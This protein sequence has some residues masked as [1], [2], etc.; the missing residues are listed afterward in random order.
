MLSVTQRTREIGIRRAVG[1]RS[2]EVLLQFILESITLSMGG[3]MIG[4]VAGVL[5]VLAISHS[6]QWSAS[7]SLWAVALSFGVS[8]AVGMFFGYYPAR[9]ASRVSPLTSLRYE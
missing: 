9:K 7:I 4:I 1:A 8:A 6:V 3:G 2:A 5:V